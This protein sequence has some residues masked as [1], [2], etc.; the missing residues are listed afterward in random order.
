MKIND[1]ITIHTDRDLWIGDYD[2]WEEILMFLIVSVRV[3]S[4]MYFGDI[5]KND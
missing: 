5:I 3:E 4:L 1:Y 2:Q